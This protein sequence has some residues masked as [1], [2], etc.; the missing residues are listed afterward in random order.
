MKF[1]LIIC[2]GKTLIVAERDFFD[3]IGI[4][5]AAK[6]VLEI[7]ITRDG[8]CSGFSWILDANGLFYKLSPSVIIK[9]TLLQKIGLRLKRVRQKIEP[10]CRIS[11]ENLSSLIINLQDFYNEAP[12]VLELKEFL[13]I[14]ESSR[15]FGGGDVARYLGVRS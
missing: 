14:E 11:I 12:L 8:D 7:N 2:D 4:L 1:P 13:S 15:L 6:G 3:R 10:G 5:D 9:P